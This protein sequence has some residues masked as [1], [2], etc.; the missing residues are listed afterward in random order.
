MWCPSRT[1]K[2]LS[3]AAAF[4]WVV[5]ESVVSDSAGLML[6]R[7]LAWADLIEALVWLT[8]LL[9][10]EV[11]VRR[12]AQGV[13]GGALIT[14]ASAIKVVLYLTLI[15][16]G[17][18]WASLSH[19]LYFWDELVWI[20]GFAAIEMNISRRIDAG[21]FAQRLIVV[22]LVLTGLILAVFGNLWAPP[23]FGWLSGSEIGA[24][25]E[26]IVPFLPMLLIGSG[27]ALYTFQDASRHSRSRIR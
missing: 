24:W 13:T 7:N 2:A 18:Y 20:G 11:V 17:V 26:L 6:E 25:V 1:G 19:W 9:A 4:Y 16:I 21:R 8:I 22:A 10:I 27:A 23:V 14:T 5:Q 15:A 12:Q 3:S